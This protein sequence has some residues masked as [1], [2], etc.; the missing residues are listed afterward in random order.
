MKVL[1]LSEAGREA[2]FGHLT[3]CLALKGAF[4]KNSARVDLVVNANEMGD[5]LLWGQQYRCFDWWN[6]RKETL[7]KV[8]DFDAVVIDSYIADAEF[9]RS[10]SQILGKRTF[11]IDDYRCIDYPKCTVINP[12]ICGDESDYGSS[13]KVEHI[14]GKDYIILREEF[15]NVPQK[16]IN[17]NPSKVL[18]TLGGHNKQD[19]L[20]DLEDLIR[21]KFGCECVAVRPAAKRYTALEMRQAMLDVDLCI[22]AGG[23]TTYEL[24]RCGVPTIGVCLADNQV[25]NLEG[26]Q[27]EGFLDYAGWFSDDDLFAKIEA[28]FRMLIPQSERIKRSQI[29]RKCVDGR[30]SSRIVEKIMSLKEVNK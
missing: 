6:N 29:G 26:W 9:Y 4:E 28:A 17:P 30:G 13:D 16:Q 2:G 3:R 19:L 22:S 1:I 25:Q 15:W 20:S 24:A 8:N 5:S 23:Q 14:L 7:K 21:N 12:S 10:C 11:A 18:I 27:R